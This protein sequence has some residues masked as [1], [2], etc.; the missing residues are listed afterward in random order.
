[1]HGTA[2]GLSGTPQQ[3]Q[4]R[5]PQPPTAKQVTYDI[6][7]FATHFHEQKKKEKQ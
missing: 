3:V 7:T 5:S 2:S 4:A 1:L 6:K